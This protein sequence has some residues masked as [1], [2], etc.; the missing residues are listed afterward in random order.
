MGLAIEGYKPIVEM[1]FADFVSVGFNQIVNNLAKTYYRWK[2]PINVTLR[3]PTGGG[4]GAGP[5]HSQSNEAWFFHVPGLKLVYPSNPLDAKGLLLSSI[6]DENPILFF[7][8]KGLYRSLSEE[9]PS[10]NFHTE[11][12]KAKIIQSGDAVTVVSYGMG[13]IWIKD[14]I[15]NN[16]SYKGL[17]EI[18]DLRTLLPWDKDAVIASIKKTNKLLIINEDNITG[19]I[20]GEISAYVAENAFEY[21]D[22][23]ILRLGSLDTP[24]PF[25][26]KLEQ[27]I[28][29][30]ANRIEETIKKLMEY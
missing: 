21:L 15:D 28:Y 20:S 30:P 29:F 7:E 22:A 11:L 25:S 4:I 14:F 24:I 23:P 1:Q 2:Q 5:F 17:L 9:V 18:I 12:G 26:Q 8:L 10:D 19:S 13:I 27:E 16:P 6:D 3:L